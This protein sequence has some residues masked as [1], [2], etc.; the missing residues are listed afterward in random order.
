M[1]IIHIIN[2]LEIGGAEKQLIKLIR[3]DKE[4]NHIVFNLI[5][6][7]SF[8]VIFHKYNLIEVRFNF[9]SRNPL[10]LIKIL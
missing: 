2:N 10:I 4:N 3:Y 8:E 1:P 5:G 6:S 7:N 9:K